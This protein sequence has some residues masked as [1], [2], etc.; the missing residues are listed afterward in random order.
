M[1]QINITKILIEPEARN[2][3]MT[4]KALNN[5]PGIP[6]AEYRQSQDG[7]LDVSTQKR[8]IQ[9]K[10]TL[11]L[12]VNKGDFVVECPCT[13]GMVGCN[14][15]I[16]NPGMNCG[17]DCAYCYLQAYMNAD[18]TTVF[19]NTN[20]MFTQLQAFLKAH[21][22]S[23]FRFGTGE[24]TDSFLYDRI[25]GL[26]S[27]LI[28]FFAGQEK[29]VIELKTKVADIDYI[30]DEQHNGNTL[31]SWSLNPD[32]V[33][34]KSEPRAPSLQKR[35]E[36]AKKAQEHQY[37]LGF[38]FDPIFHYDGWEKDYAL[39]VKKLFSAV[40]ADN[41]GWI[42]LGTFRFFPGLKAVI[43]ERFPKNNLIYGEHVR[44]DDG[45][46]RYFRKLRIQMYRTMLE[47]IRSYSKD[48]FVYLCMESPEVWGKVFDKNIMSTEE[49]DDMFIKSVF[50]KNVEHKPFITVNA[51]SGR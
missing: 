45:K 23:Y 7:Y 21:P 8:V 41:I 20:D 37:R 47:A 26:N 36:A 5:L 25:T 31:L 38:H 35:L 14:Y 29:A 44:C 1:N 42:S 50:G 43:Q 22:E 19:V 16:I 48:V 28:R 17:L 39:T 40:D 12:K 10:Q 32:S 4:K 9:G 34:K 27:E 3:P 30:N 6:V 2:Y 18:Y 13:P 24:F 51:E 11:L 46:Y 49:L 15:Y 33:I